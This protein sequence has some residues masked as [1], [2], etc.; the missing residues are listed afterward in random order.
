M[1]R[2]VL[3]TLLLSLFCSLFMACS[4]NPSSPTKDVKITEISISETKCVIDVGETITVF[5]TILP[6]DTTN[7][8][9]KWTSSNSSILKKQTEGL[10]KCEFKA[11]SEGTAKIYAIAQDGSNIKSNEITITVTPYYQVKLNGTTLGFVD[12][13]NSGSTTIYVNG[14]NYTVSYK[15]VIYSTITNTFLLSENTGSYFSNVA[16]DSYI[17]I[18][19]MCNNTKKSGTK[20]KI[21]T[22]SNV[23]TQEKFVKLHTFYYGNN[24][25]I[26][27]V[28][29]G[30]YGGTVSAGF[31]SGS[32]TLEKTIT[33]FYRIEAL[34]IGVSNLGT[35]IPISNIE[36]RIEEIS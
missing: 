3:S 32:K 1:K 10:N 11:I 6:H 26:G 5:S 17:A 34:K 14:T 36:I 16:D 22:L 7:R 15:N 25:Q 8:E 24:G 2:I 27:N 21:T 30:N 29:T 9:L 19:K 28:V 12:G 35:N 31:S 23:Q 20:V 13:I 4:S 33:N 18:G